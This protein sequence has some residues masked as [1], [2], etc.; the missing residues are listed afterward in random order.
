LIDAQVLKG[1]FKNVFLISL[2]LIGFQVCCILKSF[3]SL[4]VVLYF[5]SNFGDLIFGILFVTYE[6]KSMILILSVF[7][8]E[9]FLCF[10]V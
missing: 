8:F 7:H 10:G 4:F 1:L 5:E 2:A 9:D 6:F 3:D